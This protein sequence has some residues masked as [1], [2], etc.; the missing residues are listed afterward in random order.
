MRTLPA[1]LAAVAMIAAACA[2]AAGPSAPV[3]HASSVGVTPS[4]APTDTGS[5]SAAVSPSPVASAGGGS[6]SVIATFRTAGEEE[7]RILLTDPRDI[8]IA[9][10]LL[11][12]E[13]A[14]AIPNGR[15][16][17]GDDGGVNTGYSWHIEPDSVEFAE[18]ATEICDGRPSDVEART[19]SGDF[20]C[21]W[22][23][24]VVD[25]QPAG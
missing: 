4:V 13:E 23:A 22:S 24:V 5:P 15:I 25:I 18:L 14:P 11:A 10:R 19:L 8:Q 3:S 6:G 7:Y 16:V 17:R 12:G 1:L 20:F 2:T 21:P 9:R